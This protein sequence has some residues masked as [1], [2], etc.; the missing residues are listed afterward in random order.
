MS[1]GVIEGLVNSIS[2]FIHLGACQTLKTAP[3]LKYLRNMVAILKL[4]KPVLDEAID[5][6]MCFTKE[7][8]LFE[9]L[10]ALVNEAREIME[11]HT[12]SM[13]KICNA[14]QCE[15][16]LMKV[17]NSSM[18][19]CHLLSNLLHSTPLTSLSVRVQ[20]LECT[21]QDNTSKLIEVAL[22]DQKEYVVACPE[23]IMKIA[24]S[25]GFTSNQELLMERI[26]LEKE[27]TKAEL[28]NRKGDADHVDQVIE[29]VTQIS[30]CMTKQEHFGMINQL[31]V[32]PYFRCS[33]SLELMLDPVI[34][35][36]G[37]TY[38]RSF[39]QKWLDNGLRICPR[40]RQTLN[41]T[42]LV[43]NYTVK[44]LIANWCEENGIRIIHSVNPECVSS[45]CTSRVTLEDPRVDSSFH[46]SIKRDSASRSSGV[47][48][49]IER[50]QTE[51]PSQT[52]EEA[53]SQVNQCKIISDKAFKSDLFLEQQ[54]CGHSRSESVSS[55]NS[56]IE[57][58]SRFDDKIV[59]PPA[60]SPPWLSGSQVHCSN[61]GYNDGIIKYS[62]FPC[63]TVDHV[64][65][66]C[67]EKLLHDLRSENNEVQTAAALELRL[68]AKH[69]M[70]NRVVIAKCGA[71]APLISL[72][73]SRVKLAQ[74]NAVTALLNLSIN[75]NNKIA[76]AEAGAIGPLI[77]VL[78]YGNAVAKENAAAT[79]SSLSILEEYKIKIGGST[80]IKAL[81]DLL[82][83][84]AL[85]GKKDAAT[86]LFNLSIFHENKAR[87]VQAG[88]VKYLVNLMDPE[89]GM[90]DKAVALLAN[91]STITEGRVAI[92]QE[93]GIPLL[94]EVVETGS[95]KGKENAAST[96]LQ[97]CIHAQK[98]CNLVLQEGAVPPLIALSRLGTP[99]AKEKAQQI[100]S[101]FRCQ[102]EGICGK[103]KS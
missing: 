29:L 34:V 16:L 9:E 30:N 91:L 65:Y 37:Q 67:V 68:L 55:T 7:L 63:S 90:V 46:G 43:P 1:S 3:V 54:P 69:N 13:S 14:L 5:S 60:C 10:D 44:T 11:R 102:R 85:R 35:A 96:L 74:E 75:D 48:H 95:E 26:A 76:I 61:D 33:L 93:G 47:G 72:L 80:A 71:I 39:I 28:M 2:R 51:V 70:E 64:T 27:K 83:S 79:F 32:P 99:R 100:L 19:I 25:L 77:H 31:V 6:H 81:V 15:P 17:Q 42:N 50:Q 53:A 36:S 24:E 57:V 84:G 89:S 78:R 73:S 103:G 92:T 45:P 62:S 49:D 88:A 87:I 23:H 52:G 59:T 101:Q 66:S 18:E 97:L 21:E 38:E 22:R 41:H 4:L 40:S 86:A 98:F 94:V 56:T 8:R 82:G 20:E 12:Q 58:P